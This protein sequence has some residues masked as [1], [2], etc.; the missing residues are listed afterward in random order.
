MRKTVL[1]GVILMFILLLTSLAFSQ[2]NPN[3]QFNYPS[4]LEYTDALIQTM[5]GT[6][7]F[8][9]TLKILP[10]SNMVEYFDLSTKET[11]S[12]N[13]NEIDMLKIVNGNKAALKGLYGAGSGFGAWAVLVNAIGPESIDG[14]TALGSMIACTGCGLISGIYNGSQEKSFKIIYQNGDFVN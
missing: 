11:H 13:L 8:C 9:S 4:Q 6:Q 5:G 10:D 14:S 1:P 3:R 2:E 7:V 12:L